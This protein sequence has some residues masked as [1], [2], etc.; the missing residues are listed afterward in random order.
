MI[1]RF[2][3]SSPQ[4]QFASGNDSDAEFNSSRW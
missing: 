4:G 3:L 1:I 2:S